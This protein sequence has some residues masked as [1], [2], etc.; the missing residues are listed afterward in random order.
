MAPT[1]NISS[2]NSQ[3]G[4][5]DSGIECTLSKFANGIKLSGVV[6]MPEGQDAIQRDLDKLEKCACVN[7]MRFN[8]TKCRV[9]HLGWGN[10][11]YQYRLEDEGIESTLPRRTWGY[12]WMKSWT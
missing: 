11:W 4:V 5:Y 7:L 6:D 3:V 2:E 9:L 1:I 12:W 10:P 8:K